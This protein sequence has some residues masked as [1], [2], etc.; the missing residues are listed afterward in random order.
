MRHSLFNKCVN[1]LLTDMWEVSHNQNTCQQ[2]GWFIISD[3]QYINKSNMELKCLQLSKLHFRGLFVASAADSIPASD[4]STNSAAQPAPAKLKEVKQL[5]SCEL[6]FKVTAGFMHLRVF[7]L[8]LQ[9][10][11]FSNCQTYINCSFIWAQTHSQG[12]EDHIVLSDGRV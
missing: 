11:C 5:S 9:W 7:H 10:R 4:V 3:W 6:S 12:W 1:F 2:E 8:S